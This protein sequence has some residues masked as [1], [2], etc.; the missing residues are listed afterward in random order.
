VSH[1]AIKGINGGQIKLTYQDNTFGIAQTFVNARRNNRVVTDYPG[2]LPDSLEDGYVIQDNAIA[3]AGRPVGGWKVGRIPPHL[4][5]KYGANRL[6]GPIF[7]ETIIDSLT[8]SAEVQM[9]VLSAFAASEAELMLQINA[10]PPAGQTVDT[11]R[12]F[13]GDVRFGLEIASSPFVGIND[14]GPAVTVS[15]FGNNFG[16]VLGPKIENWQSRD[17]LNAET[18]LSIDS[19][20]VGTG[21]LCNMLDGPFG[22]A[23]FL[24][25]LL[26]DRGIILS[27][28]TWISSG[29]ITGVHSIKSGQATEAVFDGEYRVSCSTYS[30]IPEANSSEGGAS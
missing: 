23:A 2:T 8:V 24:S 10:T 14:F 1:K 25:N 12:D 19:E 20:V 16:L 28:G 4:V 11:I 5:D 30:Y 15:D 6:V 3:L 7:A 21:K 17:L 13:I 27:P 29:A 22:A 18:S 26:A 9:P